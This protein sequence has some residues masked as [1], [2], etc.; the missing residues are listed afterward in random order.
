MIHVFPHLF[1]PSSQ[2]KTRL[3]ANRDT[4]MIHLCFQFDI[5]ENIFMYAKTVKQFISLVT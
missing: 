1:T 4:S 2:K 5:I 3:L